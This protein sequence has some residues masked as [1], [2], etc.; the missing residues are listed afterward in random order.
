MISTPTGWAKVK[1]A[2]HYAGVR[3]RT[4]RKWFRMGLQYVKAP[5]GA[6]LVKYEWIDEFLEGFAINKTD[7]VNVIVNSVLSG[8]LGMEQQHEKR[9]L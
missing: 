5:T 6:I 3:D 9:N 7:D 4:L 2:A 8:V 1:E